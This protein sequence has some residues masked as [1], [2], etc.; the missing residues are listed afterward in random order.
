MRLQRLCAY[1]GEEHAIQTQ[2]RASSPCYREMA[3]VRRVKTPP[4]KRNAAVILPLRN[5]RFIVMP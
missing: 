3:Q 5:H 1:G 4:K 2:R